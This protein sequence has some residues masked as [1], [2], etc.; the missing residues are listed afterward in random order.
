[1][2]MSLKPRDLSETDRELRTVLVNRLARNRRGAG[3]ARTYAPMKADTLVRRLS[4]FNQTRL[5]AAADA[6]VQRARPNPSRG[7]VTWT[8]TL[9]YVRGLLRTSPA[10]RWVGSPTLALSNPCYRPVPDTE[11][12]RARHAWRRAA[13]E[14]ITAT[15]NGA[16]WELEEGE[17]RRSPIRTF[18]ANAADPDRDTVRLTVHVGA[19]VHE[20]LVT[21]PRS[22]TI[23]GGGVDLRTVGA[24][25]YRLPFEGDEVAL[26]ALTRAAGALYTL[27]TLHENA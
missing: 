8:E 14:A 2:T 25:T 15:L 18:V 9:S 6:A 3:E 19:G 13:W 5:G 20:G 11:A 21:S 23:R 24:P 4:D 12:V 16:G 17:S 26:A 1:M 10:V 27:A 22:V 7:P